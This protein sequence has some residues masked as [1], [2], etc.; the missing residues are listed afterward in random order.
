MALGSP[1]V[2]S[3]QMPQRPRSH[4]LEAESRLAF[5]SALGSRFVYRDESADD[6]GIDGTVEEFDGAERATG[7]RF[8]VQLKATDE[9]DLT[10]ALAVPI[11]R[12]TA[13]Y[14]RSLSLPVLMVRFCARD[15]AL[16]VRWFHQFDP[17]RGGG[18]AKTIT[19]R[20]EPGDLVDAN[21]AARLVEEGSCGLRPYGR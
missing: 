18:G 12:D 17:R 13:D 10:K 14:F 4:Q 11:R 15:R 20:W 8:H 3:A 6:Y 7:L 16:Y 1:A 2:T 9:D 21:V 5:E 19:F